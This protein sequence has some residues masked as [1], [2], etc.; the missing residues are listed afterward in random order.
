[1][2]PEVSGQQPRQGGDHSTVSPARLRAGDLPTQD[3]N[4]VPEHQDLRILR[5]II[6]RQER[7]PADHTDHEEIDEADEHKRRA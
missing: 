4:L 6:S 5:N 2:Q 7:Q 1:M 3:G